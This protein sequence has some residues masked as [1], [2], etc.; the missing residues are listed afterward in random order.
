[1]LISMKESMGIKK[2]KKRRIDN[3]IMVSRKTLVSERFAIM[4]RCL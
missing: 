2:K 3:R 1:M 4:L